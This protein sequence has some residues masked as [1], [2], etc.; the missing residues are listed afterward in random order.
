MSDRLIKTLVVLLC[1]ASAGIFV[2]MLYSRSAE[3]YPPYSSLRLDERGT[4]ILYESLE[5]S[6]AYRVTRSFLPLDQLHTANAD[7]L[8]IGVWPI[9]LEAR[10]EPL[11]SSFENLASHGNRVLVGL[12]D[13]VFD[14][15]DTSAL[16]RHGLSFQ[17]VPVSGSQKAT[18][19]RFRTSNAWQVMRQD[20]L[21]I[22]AI[23]R[24]YG[25]GSLILLADSDLFLN[26]MLAQSPDSTFLLSLLG[27]KQEVIF[28]E[29]HLGIV[30]TGS[31]I[32]LARH[33]HLDG[34]LWGLLLLAGFFLWRNIPS[35]PPRLAESTG[36][37]VSWE[38]SFVAFRRLLE[39]SLP[40][41]DLLNYC[42]EAR[43]QVEKKQAKRQALESA[44]PESAFEKDT[45]R[46]FQFLQSG[47]NR[48][49]NSK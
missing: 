23:E 17:W 32:G 21:G 30:E 15:K 9:A 2:A 25:S 4:T 41:A 13:S 48:G 7:I 5:Q 46:R 18:H 31:V 19:R 14:V 39:K 1:L 43:M 16:T 47:L 42:V 8:L 24:G 40:S 45:V 27:S 35:F 6:G 36:N 11:W 3:Y 44:F 49:R 12:S 22:E 29:S 37:A 26:R 28:N 34:L 20:A 10:S 33:Y 38:G